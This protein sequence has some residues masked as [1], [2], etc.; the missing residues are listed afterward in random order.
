VT[1]PV[2]P[3]RLEQVEFSVVR[4]G[5]DPDAVRSTLAEAADGLRLLK[6]R[7]HEFEHRIETL[8]GQVP[9]PE[10]L[11]AEREAARAEGRV[12]GETDAER[13]REDALSGAEALLAEA[14]EEGRRLVGE[15]QTIRRRML[16]D[17][18][19]RRRALRQQIE[20]LRGGRERLLEA[21]E[22]VGHTMR[23]ATAELS[24]AL[25]EARAAAERA[26]HGVGPEETVEQLEAEIESARLVGLPI[27]AEQARPDEQEAEPV[28]RRRPVAVP[29]ERDVR[30]MPEVEPV[31][32]D[33]EEVRVLPDD[34]R[35]DDS[36]SEGPH[37]AAAGNGADD[38]SD[39]EG[40]DDQPA[41][42]AGGGQ[43]ETDAAADDESGGG[44]AVIEP[45]ETEA[46]DSD[47]DL[48]SRLRSSRSEP[49]DEDAT[50][51]D[52]TDSG[53]PAVETLD[54]AADA[55][56]DGAPSV[57]PEHP[58]DADSDP[59]EA[60]LG[61]QQNLDHPDDATEPFGLVLS[62]DT[63]GASSAEEVSEQRATAEHDLARRL[64][65]LLS[66]EQNDVLDRLRRTRKRTLVVADLLDELDERVTRFADAVRPV[67]AEAAEVE[68]GPGAQ[69]VDD[70]AAELARE[71]AE[72]V[73][74]GMVEPLEEEL[75][76][77]EM[78][79]SVRA[80]YRSW[81]TDRIGAFAERY[82]DAA[83]EPAPP[84]A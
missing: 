61:A 68:A 60:D 2:D 18:A 47:E 57:G 5:L 31:V 49:G 21:Y 59:A 55:G 30:D 54:E 34:T 10:H 73:A 11:E 22:V 70:L 53:L 45:P 25:P 36:D 9:D 4:R 46:S 7:C 20:Q 43:P 26:G 38:D 74:D 44:A 76:V 16:E 67:L 82:V 72:A 33:F 62:D 19:R 79:G 12:A 50:E 66:D 41:T 32:A 8:E 78:A 1:E 23:E 35:G 63:A 39:T 29:L 52:D 75:P 48:F 81:K 42:E 64:K 56:A 51:S 13:Q 65:R 83:C 24:V 40:G 37:P 3:D 15:A 80:L 77:D 58:T 28:G 6:R 84:T 71:V 69:P 14:K 27:A 17:L